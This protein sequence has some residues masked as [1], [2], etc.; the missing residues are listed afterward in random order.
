MKS[1]I[2]IGILFFLS[3]I[4]GKEK[5][6]SADLKRRS[7]HL[8][9]T[10]RES[11]SKKDIISPVHDYGDIDTRELS[12]SGSGSGSG[13]GNKN[14]GNN[15]DDGNKQYAY[16]YSSSGSSSS[17]WYAMTH[18]NRS[19]VVGLIVGCLGLSAIGVALV[20]LNKKRKDEIDTENQIEVK[21]ANLR[22][23][24]PKR[25]VGR[26]HPD[27]EGA[28]LGNHYY[29]SDYV[30]KNVPV[31]TRSSSHREYQGEQYD[32]R[33]RMYSRSPTRSQREFMDRAGRA[34]TDSIYNEHVTRNSSRSRSRSDRNGISDHA[35]YVHEPSRHRESS[36]NR[37]VP[38]RMGSARQMEAGYYTRRE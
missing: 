11:R 5:I 24:R 37:E 13:D 20:F 23:P 17:T 35:Q 3:F 38:S 12:G 10:L 21:R 28:E 22:M 7:L 14:D 25:P 8:D 32:G 27:S 15:K 9:S 16:A 36:V 1:Y 30:T 34:H 2:L 29:E 26:I 33:P 18:P 6:S 19:L 4:E 31:N